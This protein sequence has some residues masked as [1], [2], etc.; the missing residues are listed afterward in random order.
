M[1]AILEYYLEDGHLES[2]NNYTNDTTEKERVIYEVIRVIN[3][4]PLFYEDHIKR[5]ESS[6][7]L[8]EKPFS[9]KYDKIKDY[10]IRLIDAN[11]L[12]CGN[13]KLTFDIK[14][15]TMKVFTIKHNYPSNDMY[16]NGVETIL[17]HGERINPNAKV[18]DSNFRKKVTDKIIK[19]NVFEAILVNSNG[20]ITEGSKSNIFMIKEEKLYTSPLE[21][22][23]PGVTRG[24]II[25]LAKNL[26]ITFE[27]KKINFNDLKEIDAMF[28]S[29]TSPK[30]LPISKVDDINLNIENEIMRKLIKKFDEEIKLYVEK[31]RY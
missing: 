7:R 20:F 22:V 25:S 27:E 14:T 6:F 17:Y 10:L 18:V 11:N 23:L 31:F 4:V 26:G 19:S 15:D 13:I 12:E 3:K 5:L 8:M 9:Y 1:E 28:I 16:K 24:R 30:I 21:D 2:I 29:G